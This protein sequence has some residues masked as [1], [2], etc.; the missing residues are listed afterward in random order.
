VEKALMPKAKQDELTEELLELAT[1]EVKAWTHPGGWWSAEVR[2]FGGNIG[3]ST[4]CESFLQA[5]R[6]AART[7]Y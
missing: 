4:E 2:T 6:C 5:V 3:R 7:L 1:V